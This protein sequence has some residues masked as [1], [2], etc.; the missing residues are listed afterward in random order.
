[1]PD[2]NQSSPGKSRPDATLKAFPQIIE[3]DF[4]ETKGKICSCQRYCENRNQHQEGGGIEKLFID[5]PWRVIS[6]FWRF[7]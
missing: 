3:W 6:G 7:D 1:M 5:M 4:N 2:F